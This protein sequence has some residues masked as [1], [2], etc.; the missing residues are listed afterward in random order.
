MIAGAALALA[1]AAVLPA[2]LDLAR[3]CTAGEAVA[4]DLL[5]RRLAERGAGT[6]N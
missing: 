3:P 1:V 6:G 4:S 5:R 2:P